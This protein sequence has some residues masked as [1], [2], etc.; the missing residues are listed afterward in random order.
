MKLISSLNPITLLIVVSLGSLCSA[1]AQNIL[2]VKTI[3]QSIEVPF[4]AQTTIGQI[5][6]ALEQSEGI[7]AN[8]QK[9]T[10]NEGWTIGFPPKQL[11]ITLADNQTCAQYGLVHNAE[12]QLWLKLANQSV[13]AAPGTAAAPAN[14]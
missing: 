1:A 7:P 8:Q 12:V 6:Q 11:I 4:T 5:K 9:L 2:K 14:S 3:K 10:K 13:N